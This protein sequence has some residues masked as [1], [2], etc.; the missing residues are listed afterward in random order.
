MMKPMEPRKNN[1]QQLSPSQTQS[2]EAVPVPATPTAVTPTQHKQNTPSFIG[3]FSPLVVDIASVAASM[4]LGV[5]TALHIIDERAYKNLTSLYLTEDV[6]D[7]RRLEGPR[8]LREI[9]YGKY[10]N[11]PQAAYID[12]RDTIHSYED[13]MKARFAKANITNTVKKFGLL[14]M[15][16]KSEV[17]ITA[18]SAFALSVG[19]LF[20]VTRSLIA[21]KEHEKLSEKHAPEKSEATS[22]ALPAPRPDSFVQAEHAKHAAQPASPSIAI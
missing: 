18:L 11:N 8:I 12:V 4:G 21:E 5:V 9:M 13:K 16:Q 7:H 15:H 6:K 19:T 14:R 20:V 2:A 17:A 22:P 3:M 1:A 10:R